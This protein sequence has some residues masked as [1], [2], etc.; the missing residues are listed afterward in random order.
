MTHPNPVPRPEDDLAFIRRLMEGARETTSDNGSYLIL[1]G[2]VLAAA[3]AVTH[4]VGIGII[5]LSGGLVWAL[6]VG[7]GFAVS[8]LLG[9]RARLR[10]P[11]NSLVSRILAAIWIGCGVGL[12]V[13]GF[14]G[15]RSGSV[16]VLV[17]SG[18]NAT[19]IGT[20]FFASSF[21]PG[22]T[23][24]RLLA[25]IW[26]VIAGALLIWPFSGSKLVMSAALIAFMAGP[27]L[28]LKLRTSTVSGARVIA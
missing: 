12:S 22:R 4:L 18:V 10:A 3:E 21:L 13:V 2:C 14:L 8:V 26:W 19:F 7:L 9:H 27:G 15:I 16:Q 25:T 1:W 17:G 20:A 5:T 11:V 6:A 24:Y 23:T 28:V